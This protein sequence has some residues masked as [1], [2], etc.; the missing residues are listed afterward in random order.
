M[1]ALEEGSY[2][3]AFCALTRLYICIYGLVGRTGL[4]LAR[5]G[6]HHEWLLTDVKATAL[7]PEYS[8]ESYG[9]L[10]VASREQRVSPPISFLI[11]AD[12]RCQ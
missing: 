4:W 10:G 3:V 5:C 11:R 2:L 1:G 8:T 9:R 12:H 6:V 7:F